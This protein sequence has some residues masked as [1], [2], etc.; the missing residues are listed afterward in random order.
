MAVEVMNRVEKKFL[1]D[2][3]T[4]YQLQNTVKDFMELDRFNKVNEFYTISNL[5]LDTPDN[6]LIRTSIGKPLYKEKLRL[7]AYG[8]PTDSDY[9][10]LEIKKKYKGNVNKRRTRLLL[11]EAYQFIETGVKP[12][13]KE[14][15]NEQV[16]NEL[17]YCLKLYDLSPKLY[18]AYDRKAFFG[19]SELRVTFDTNIRTRRVD[20][21][22]EHGDYGACLMNNDLWLM[23]IKSATAMPLWLTKALSLLKIYSNG[24]SKYGAE[25]IHFLEGGEEK[26][27][28]PY[29]APHKRWQPLVQQVL[30][31]QSA[32]L[33]S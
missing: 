31:P 17:A 20:L 14:Y 19:P 22:L 16:L 5:Y 13:P 33:F 3:E 26:C 2:S 1:L 7:R 32:S 12:L 6:H 23:E 9:V 28:N 30:S 10:Y 18:L 29:L 15:M 11:P 21:R 8:V 4:Y 24:F 25:Y 27:S